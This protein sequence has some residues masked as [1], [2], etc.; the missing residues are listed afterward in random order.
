L[1]E[2]LFRLVYGAHGG[3]LTHIA[4]AFTLLGEGWVV[5][6]LL[7]FLITRRYRSPAFALL[8]VFAVTAAAVAL[9]KLAFHRVRPCNALT[10]VRCLWLDAPTDYSFPSG[11]AAGSFAFVAFIG[12]LV[13]FSPE[14]RKRPALRLAACALL[15]ATATCIALSRVYLGVHFPGDVAAG[16][17]LGVIL[18]L[19]GARV[20][21][22]RRATGR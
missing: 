11:H 8:G 21:L 13:L 9:L 20:H 10:G 4:A 6:G 1:D 18:G 3:A 16:S 15:L 22:G 2:Y 19:V 14:S 12:S 7:P 5:L 17:F